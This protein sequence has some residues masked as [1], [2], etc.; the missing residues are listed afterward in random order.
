VRTVEAQ[1]FAVGVLD[2]PAWVALAALR[3]YQGSRLCWW[4]KILWLLS[5]VWSRLSIHRGQQ[6]ARSCPPNS[7]LA[8]VLDFEVSYSGPVANGSPVFQRSASLAVFD[9]VVMPVVA[10]HPETH[11]VAGWD[12]GLDFAA[13]D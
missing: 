4:S 1:D 9:L 7:L 6:E 2:R 8:T 12:L 5:K 10:G 11:G 13:E 3:E